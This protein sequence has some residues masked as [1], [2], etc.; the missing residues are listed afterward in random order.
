MP[1]NHV[2]R[3]IVYHIH[4]GDWRVGDT[5]Y[6]GEKNNRFSNISF[7]INY[8]DLKARSDELSR[9]QEK[10]AIIDW[11]HIN[12]REIFYINYIIKQLQD[13][14]HKGKVIRDLK[15]HKNSLQEINSMLMRENSPGLNDVID[16]YKD[17]VG[18]LRNYLLFMRERIFE[19]VRRNSF[20]ALPSRLKCLWVIEDNGNINEA[21]NY[22]W[23]E[24][25][26]NG[27]LIKLELNGNLFQSDEKYLQLK[28]E[29]VE[30][31]KS[32]AES[33]W[34][35]K[36]GDDPTYYECLFIGKAKVL[37]VTRKNYAEFEEQGI[38]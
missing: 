25:S 2:E 33:Y 16:E 35:G 37:E 8:D 14:V 6:I 18:G 38:N 31:M 17:L 30:S 34:Q 3:K 36:L 1:L 15:S 22:W 11:T 28:L 27:Q 32:K 4:K 23:N 26:R 9:L 12:T 5:C 7:N 20:P 10:G 13:S 19:N 21:I 24:L 29:S